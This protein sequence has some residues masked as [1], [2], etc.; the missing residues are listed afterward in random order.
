[1]T[2]WHETRAILGRSLRGTQ[3]NPLFIAVSL[4]Q[5]LLY[6]LL[7]APLLTGLA[8]T[9]GVGNAGALTFFTPGLLVILALFGGAFAGL[10]ILADLKAGVIDRWRVTPMHRSALI[11]GMTLGTTLVVVIQSVVLLAVAW[12][13][14][15]RASGTGVALTVLFVAVISLGIAAASYALALVTHDESAMTAIIQFVAVPLPLLSGIYLPFTLAPVWLRTV[16]TFNP[17][18]HGVEAARALFLGHT[19]HPEVGLGVGLML[20][21]TVVAFIWAVQAFRRVAR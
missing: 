19:R 13:M 20:S 17:V 1:M 11:L 12:L 21:L 7:F 3:R 18:Y 9:V 14:G 2:L 16:A 4:V 10:G 5:P 6:L 8:G 15:M